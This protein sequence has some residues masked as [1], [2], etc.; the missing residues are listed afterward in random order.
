[1]SFVKNFVAFVL[2]EDLNTKDTKEAQSMVMMMV[3]LTTSM[4][5]DRL[6]RHVSQ[7]SSNSEPQGSGRS[8]NRESKMHRL[9]H[10]KCK[11]VILG[12]HARSL[13]DIISPFK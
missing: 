10:T 4:P 6:P 2:R 8:P 1:V 13:G 11:M 12:E 3:V 9:G 5:R 7:R